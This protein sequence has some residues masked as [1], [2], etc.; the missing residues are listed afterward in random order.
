MLWD[1]HISEQ[2][3]C[4]CIVLEADPA[5]MHGD[6]T[7]RSFGG[8]ALPAAEASDDPGEPGEGSGWM[9]VGLCDG[10]A[11]ELAM[12]AVDEGQEV[13]I[14]GVEGGPRAAVAR[15]DQLHDPGRG[16]GC[17]SDELGERRGAV[18]LTGL[19]V[20]TLELE[21]AE[22][23]LDVPAQAVELDDPA[24]GLGGRGGM[25]YQH[26]PRQGVPGPPTGPLP[27]PPPPARP[28]RWTP[29]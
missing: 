3:P 8:I 16:D 21:R 12:Q 19:D 9:P 17:Q 1:S 28:P 22:Q 29:F 6:G 2:P 10:R 14:D 20:E 15:G 27:P 11:F 18:D 23:L 5:V 24:C 4:L 25:T 26:A 13:G 7:G